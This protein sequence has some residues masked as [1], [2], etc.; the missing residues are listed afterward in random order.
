MF[1]LAIFEVDT[2]Q[3]FAKY[4]K[5]LCVLIH[6]V[7]HAQ[8]MNINKKMCKIKDLQHKFQL[9]YPYYINYIY[10]HRCLHGGRYCLFGKIVIFSFFLLQSR[11]SPAQRLRHCMCCRGQCVC[12]FSRQS[13]GREHTVWPHVI[14]LGGGLQH[15]C[16]H[17]RHWI[18]DR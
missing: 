11:Q 17:G 6:Y 12:T 10:Q 3:N 14:S 2:A 5:W 15:W 7:I 9:V 4:K 1:L 13:S 18:M 16:L 8:I